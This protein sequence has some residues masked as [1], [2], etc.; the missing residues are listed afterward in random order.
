[1]KFILLL[2]YFQNDNIFASIYDLIYRSQGILLFILCVGQSFSS[3]IFA[4]VSGGPFVITSITA[5]VASDSLAP[6]SKDD[7]QL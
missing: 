4:Y 6:Q 5:G 3:K 2:I 1:M 7:I